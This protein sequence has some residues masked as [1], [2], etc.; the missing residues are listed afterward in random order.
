MSNLNDLEKEYLKLEKEN[1]PDGKR[2]KFIANLGA[3]GEIAYHYELICKQWQEGWQL[4]LE[5][6]FD[7]HGGAGLE[8]LFERLAKESDQ[9]LK[10]DTIYLIAQILSKSKHRDFYTAFCDRL[11]PQITSFSETNDALRRKLIIALGWVGS[12]EQIEILISEMLNSKDSLCRAW[13]AASLMQMSF[14]RASQ[15]SLRDKTK[16]AFLQGIS[17]EKELYACAIMIEAA[18][19]LFGKKWISS[20]AVQNQEAEKIEKARKMAVRFF[21]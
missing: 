3:S 15:E 13:A 11:V 8:F 21:I 14:H 19:I 9:K 10:V 20:S 18:Q 7:R 5:S 17:S 12:L 2:I 6:S 1:F 4:N 16:A